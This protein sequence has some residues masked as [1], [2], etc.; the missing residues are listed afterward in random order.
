M[1]KYNYYDKKLALTLP[2]II[3]IA[4]VIFIGWRGY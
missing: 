1:D 3:I 4:S 2:A